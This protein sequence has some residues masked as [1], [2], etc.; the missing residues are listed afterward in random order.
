MRKTNNM[1]AFDND[2]RNPIN[3]IDDDYTCNI[4]DKPIEQEGYCSIRCKQ[5]DD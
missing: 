1:E 5:A 2:H 3:F 4:C